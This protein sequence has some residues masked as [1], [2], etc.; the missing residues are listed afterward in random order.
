MRAKPRLRFGVSCPLRSPAS[1]ARAFPAFAG[2]ATQGE[3][4][5]EVSRLRPGA[6]GARGSRPS[7]RG[8]RRSRWVGESDYPVPHGSQVAVAAGVGLRVV[9]GV[10]VEFDHEAPGLADEVGDVRG[11]WVPGGGTAGPAG[12]RAVV[13][14]GCLRRAWGRRAWRGRGR[15][16]RRSRLGTGQMYLRRRA[17]SRGSCCCA[18]PSPLGGRV[19][20]G[21]SARVHGCAR[22]SPSE[23]ERLGVAHSLSP[24]C[25]E[26]V[27]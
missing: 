11:R 21:A 24:A 26:R 15:R 18:R 13:R 20:A 5:T 14:R 22:A 23:R 1:P 7:R 10:A 19:V 8:A 3:G 4:A 27:G 2:E 16:S 9:T 17:G 25:R 12:C 6:A